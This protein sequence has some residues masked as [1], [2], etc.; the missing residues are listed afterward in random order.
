MVSHYLLVRKEYPGFYRMEKIELQAVARPT[1]S[2]E[3]LRKE[4][5][6]P[7]IIY[8]HGKA[9]EHLA[10]SYSLFDKAFR[11]AGESTLVNLVI[12]GKAKN[13][14][15]QDVQRHYLTGKYIHADFYEV[16]M[17]EKLKA[18]VQLEFI[19]VSNAVKAN[20]GTLVTVLQE[21]EVECLPA[22]LPHNFVVDISVLN[23]FED[24]IHVKDLK[25]DSKVEILT[26]HEEMVAKV[27]PPRD[28]E[29]ELAAPIVED[30]S[31]VEGAA[32]TKPEDEA[33]DKAD[34][35]E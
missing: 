35:K 6:I 22:D 26:D 19:G 27:N 15:I 25:V 32:E 33:A 11:K 9:T 8:G 24:S 23:T 34:K 12:E 14:I 29:A 17:T 3:K 7:A 13:V 16:S 20:G 28:V 5:S 4:G 30:V 21:V 31:K 1:Y 18:T 2:V 10:L